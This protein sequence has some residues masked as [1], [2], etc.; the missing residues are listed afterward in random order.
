M[1]LEVIV[2]DDGSTD[3]TPESVQK[4]T[5]TGSNIFHQSMKGFEASLN[6][7]QYST[8]G[9]DIICLLDA[10]DYFLNNKI[11]EVLKEFSKNKDLLVFVSR[12]KQ[13]ID[14]RREEGS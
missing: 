8:Q 3:N 4:V 5:E 6:K 7:S 14:Q 13:L 10:D 1:E 11:N 9:G 2:I 12:L